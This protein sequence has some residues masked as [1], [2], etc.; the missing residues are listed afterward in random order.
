VARWRIRQR[1]WDTPVVSDVPRVLACDDAAGFRIL[2][3][4]LLEAG[5]FAV[6]GLVGSWYEAIERVRVDAPDAIL[7]DLWMPTFDPALLREL[8]E[9]A[10]RSHVFIVTG[11]PLD[12]A[13]RMVRDVPVAGVFSKRGRPQL[14]VDGLREAFFSDSARA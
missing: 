2:M 10:P 14:V 12:E 5:G 13:Q 8:T 1:A 11:L 4:A 3:R 7:A 6:A 9:S